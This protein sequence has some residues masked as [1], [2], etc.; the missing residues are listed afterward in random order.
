MRTADSHR[1]SLPPSLWTH[2]RDGFVADS[3]RAHRHAAPSWRLGSLLPGTASGYALTGPIRADINALTSANG[4]SSMA[5]PPH[6][7]KVTGSIPAGTTDNSAAQTLSL[8]PPAG[9]VPNT[10]QIPPPHLDQRP[11]DRVD[12]KVADPCDVNGGLAS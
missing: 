11:P 8:R 5:K 12:N 4:I 2:R 7:Q 9:F 6:T 3:R 1:F 10:C